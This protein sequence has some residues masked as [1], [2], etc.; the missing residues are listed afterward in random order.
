M[1][2]LRV[3]SV[4]LT[5]QM[6]VAQGCGCLGSSPS[7]AVDLTSVS[8]SAKMYVIILVCQVTISHTVCM[9]YTVAIRILLGH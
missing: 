2:S 6:P 8:S 9:L 7:S 1:D 5:S 3:S 4:I